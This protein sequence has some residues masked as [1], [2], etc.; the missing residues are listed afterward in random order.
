MLAWPLAAFGGVYPWAYVPWF[1]GSLL[2]ALLS[3]PRFDRRARAT[4]IGLCLVL[5]AGLAQLLPLPA[6][7][8]GA[9]AP[10]ALT[11]RA[12]L[13]LGRLPA[14][15]P[16]SIDP[17]GTV[18]ALA[19]AAAAFLLYWS[20]RRTLGSSGVR[21]V[22]RAI[23]WLGLLMACGALIQLGASRTRIYGF[24]APRDPGALPFGPFV[25]R[26]H[27]ATWLV[28]A[29]PLCFG[30][31]LARLRSATATQA[32]RMAAFH[33]ALD[34]RT[35]WLAGSGTIMLLALAMTLSRSGVIGIATA[36]AIAA[37]ISR[38][39]LDPARKAWAAGVVLVAALAV[40]QFADVLAVAERFGQSSQG[41]AGRLRV[42][43]DTIAMCRSMWTTGS[44]V[45]TFQEAMTIF[46]TGDRTYYFNHAHNHYL[47]AAAEG[48][49]LVTGPVILALVG[50][51]S[52]ARS[53]LMAEDS[54]LLWIR[55]GAATG[56]LAAAVQSLWD[57]GLRMPANAALAAVLAAIL[58]HSRRRA[59]PAPDAGSVQW[60]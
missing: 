60:P 24:W 12:A 32:R 50:L 41:A 1:A 42:W 34:S 52:L 19:I 14:S 44:G 43:Q 54:G 46:Q 56:L 11:L 9:V 37:I 35:V 28:M 39:R 3:A 4:D 53:R 49:V 57:T 6:P 16:L 51:V 7:I 2:L 36:A 20:A 58:T 30:Y 13:T 23:G 59:A 48:G 10:G 18:Q 38:S 27:A 33:H 45:G 21:L 26:N 47:Q 31:L 8:V 29:I 15:L 17:M 25:S 40:L 5:L 22:C 55:A